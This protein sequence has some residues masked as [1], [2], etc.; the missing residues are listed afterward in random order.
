MTPLARHHSGRITGLWVGIAITLLL[1]V[2]N[3]SFAGYAAYTLDRANDTLN[4]GGYADGGNYGTVTVYDSTSGSGGNIAGL[5]SNQLKIVFSAPA[6][7]TTFQE[8]GFSLAGT[9]TLSGITVSASNN[10]SGVA[11]TNLTLPPAQQLDGMGDFEYTARKD[12]GNG[13][14]ADVIEIVFTTTGAATIDQF[15]VYSNGAQHQVYFAAHW[16]AP[17][18]TGWVGG[19][20]QGN[21]NN[22]GNAVPAPPSAIAALS[23]LVVFGLVGCARLRR[24]PQPVLAA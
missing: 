20:Q 19:P 11:W 14:R 23:G 6:G 21:N 5:A 3:V 18:V 22:Q 10:G 2:S 17:T 13:N 12:S 9:H 15:M 1:F 7:T 24:R 4:S 16:I 8:I